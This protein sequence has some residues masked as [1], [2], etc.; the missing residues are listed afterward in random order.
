M[1]ITTAEAVG[2]KSGDT[3]P[4]YQLNMTDDIGDIPPAFQLDVA[5]DVGTR[6][7]ELSSDEDES[8]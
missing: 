7:E 1:P 4:S 6:A 3:A 8:E 2:R 5:D